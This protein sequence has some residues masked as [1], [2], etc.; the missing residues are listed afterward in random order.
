M[1]NVPIET[2]KVI[3]PP[4]GMM[5]DLEFLSKVRDRITEIKAQAPVG[6]PAAEAQ[7]A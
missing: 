6:Q 4:E 5:T 1:D 2:R 3:E 7:G